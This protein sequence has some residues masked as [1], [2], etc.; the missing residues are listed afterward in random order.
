MTAKMRKAKHPIKVTGAI[1]HGVEAITLTMTLTKEASP[2]GNQVEVGRRFKLGNQTGQRKVRG[3]RTSTI[4]DPDRRMS[5]EMNLQGTETTEE[6]EAEAILQVT[7][8][9][10]VTKA[11]KEE[12]KESPK[13]S[14]DVR[15]AA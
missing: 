13:A 12:A 8:R 14:T 7:P 5:P 15:R 2:A 9:H 1:G 10:Q 6:V 11:Q 3:I 4:P